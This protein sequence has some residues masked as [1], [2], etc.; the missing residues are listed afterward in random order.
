MSKIII[1]N[2]DTFNSEVLNA[3]LPVLAYFSAPWVN[4]CSLLTPTLNDLAGENAEKVK[5]VKI[6]TDDNDIC[7]QRYG[8]KA[9]PTLIIF[10]DGKTVETMVGTRSKTQLQDV[11]SKY[12]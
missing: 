6:N 4:E 8:I 9:M 10:K 5:V 1:V 7:T 11:I 2:D 3:N 12:L